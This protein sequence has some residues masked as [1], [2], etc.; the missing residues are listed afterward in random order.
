MIEGELVGNHRICAEL[1][2]AVVHPQDTVA[3]TILGRAIDFVVIETLPS[4]VRDRLGLTSTTSSRFRMR[5]ARRVL[6]KIFPALPPKV[7]FYPE[8]LKAINE[9]RASQ[10]K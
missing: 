2:R 10:F 3:A 7:R 8:Y 5:L 4:K 6:Q 1:A 9:L